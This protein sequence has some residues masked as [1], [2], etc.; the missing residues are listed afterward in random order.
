[1]ISIS[2]QLFRVTFLKD[3]AKTMLLLHICLCSFHACVYVYRNIYKPPLFFLLILVNIFP[4]P[5]TQKIFIL[6]IFPGIGIE[7]NITV[8]FILVHF[9]LIL[10]YHSS[11]SCSLYFPYHHFALMDCRCCREY[12]YKKI[13]SSST[14]RSHFCSL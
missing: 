3:H 14:N 12:H 10:M 2:I 9:W 6:T 4:L 1:M 11:F 13:M 7:T 5:S 8:R